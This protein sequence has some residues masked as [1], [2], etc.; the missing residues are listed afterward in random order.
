MNKSR[1]VVMILMFI[2]IVSALVVS[3]HGDE[4]KQ[5][6][7]PNAAE[8]A[9]G[10]LDPFNR[11]DK[12]KSWAKLTWLSHAPSTERTE[13]SNTDAGEMMKDAVTKSFETS[14]E[15]AEH[16]AKVAGHSVHKTAEK[17]KRTLSGSG[18]EDEEH[19]L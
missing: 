7:K 1:G 17:V 11:W 6:Q 13:E 2:I 4:Q 14:K 16:T 8:R 19:E 3:I 5:K 10:F 15:T 12:V 18:Q 9:I